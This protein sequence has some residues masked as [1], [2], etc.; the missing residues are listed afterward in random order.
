MNESRAIKAVKGDHHRIYP[1]DRVPLKILIREHFTA[2]K[3]T[4][5]L[6]CLK[7][8]NPKALATP[9]MDSKL[10]SIEG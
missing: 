4:R 1:Y 3:P 8:G 2:T 5:E 6:S 9:M 10:R 7:A